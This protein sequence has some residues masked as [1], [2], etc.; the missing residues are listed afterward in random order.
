[1]N[2]YIL[3]AIGVVI[4]C[5]MPIIGTLDDSA[6]S[7]NRTVRLSIPVTDPVNIRYK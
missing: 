6:K 4:L 3:A 5:A 1:M 2:R 7:D